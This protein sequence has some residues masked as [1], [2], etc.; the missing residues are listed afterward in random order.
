MGLDGVYTLNPE[1]P[2][3]EANGDQSADNQ[4]CSREENATERASLGHRVA[5]FTLYVY[6]GNLDLPRR[7]GEISQYLSKYCDG[8][9]S[10]PSARI[11]VVASGLRTDKSVRMG[12]RH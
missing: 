8:M 1:E 10:A 2:L 7:H 5:L 11:A 12:G 4:P 6:Q 3:N 9:V